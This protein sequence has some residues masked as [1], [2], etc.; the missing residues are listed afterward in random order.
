MNLFAQQDIVKQGLQGFGI[1]STE[2][3]M[4]PELRDPLCERVVP[5]VCIFLPNLLLALSS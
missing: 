5:L 2:Q 3:D 1:Q 4:A